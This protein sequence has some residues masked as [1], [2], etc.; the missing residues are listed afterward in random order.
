MDSSNTP[1]YAATI[2]AADCT[3]APALS[4]KKSKRGPAFTNAKDVIIARA[5][6]TA[7]ENAIYGAHQ[8]GKVFKLHMFEL[9]KELINEQNQANQTLLEQLSNATRDEYLKQGVGVSLSYRSAKSVF[10]RFK[11][12]ILPEVMKYMGITKTTDIA[13]GWSM[14]DHKIACLEIYK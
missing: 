6:I 10:N 11:S 4:L 9:Y 3:T 2:T 13:S 12:Q 5:F 8:K 7:S 1:P 14:D